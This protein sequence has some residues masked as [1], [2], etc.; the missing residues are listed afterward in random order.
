MYIP[1][2]LELNR[3]RETT[4]TAEVDNTINSKKITG[5]TQNKI[6][7]PDLFLKEESNMMFYR[8]AYTVP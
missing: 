2:E 7:I 3:V 5:A 1:L 4:K 8:E 6:R